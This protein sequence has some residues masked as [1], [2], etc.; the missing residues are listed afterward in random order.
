MNRS[1]ACG[2]VGVMASLVACGGSAKAPVVP[3]TATADAGVAQ[4]ATATA[5]SA[6][7]SEESAAVPIAS[8][9][10]TWGNRDALVTVVAFEDIQCPFCARTAPTI[11]KLEAEYGPEKLRVVWKHLPLPF[12]PNARPAAEAAE[13]VRALGGNDAFWKFLEQAFANQ[14]ELGADSYAKWASNAGVDATAFANGAK[15]GVWAAKVQRDLATA[16]K[17]GVDGTPA[18]LVNGA[19]ITGAQPYEA[20]KQTVDA[21]LTQAGL[22][23]VSGTSRVGVYAAAAATNFKP[24]PADD[25][26][27]K[28][29]TNVYK[30]PVG[31]SP[32][33]GATTAPVTIVEF[34]DYQC[35]YCRRAAETLEKVRAKYGD[36]VRLVWKNEPLP[37]HPHAEPAAELALEARAE[38]GD[39]GFWAAHDALFAAT[40]LEESDL[41]SIA[42]DLK[43]DVAKVKSAIT[44][45]KYAKAIEE[46]DTVADGFRATGTPHF[47]IDGRRVVG[48]QPLEKFVSIIDDELKKTQALATKGV[49][50]TGMYDAL[51]AGGVAMSGPEKKDVAIP[52]AN[53]PSRG[54]STAKVVVQEF[55]DFQCPYCKRAE[56]S[57]D[58]LVAAYPGRVRIVWRNL[59][60]NQIH[61]DAQLAAEAALEAQAQKGQAG[62]WKMHA[63]LFANQG[64]DG[65]L[66]RE[67]L[68][69]YA[70]A[71]GLDM[72][73]WAAALDGHTHKDAID[74]DV[75]AADAAGVQ[76]APAFFINGYFL[77]GA[78]PYKSFQRLVDRA[79]SE[80]A[81]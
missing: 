8:D 14:K 77:D 51:V 15:S 72:K 36:S 41:L 7:P 54:A 2:L 79:L 40:G 49:T 18:F 6:A 70:K 67:A 61:P 35:P 1:F 16:Q 45:K 23:I 50:A 73:K 37:F 64:V 66:Q 33:R 52:S 60:L 75:K 53:A 5:L 71:L 38:K 29:D 59:P 11:Q 80:P 10:A 32:V 22:L 24:Q 20:F 12:H 81:R 13:G 68:D 17:L 28:D 74:A 21:A 34:G 76:G 30:V 46:D 9:D 69:G 63:L 42:H 31:T 55:A 48:S 78:M 57:I 47:F 65:A 4:A 26:N 3:Q 19:W 62:F 25:D 44:T 43:L 39:A 27:A 56:D 58:K